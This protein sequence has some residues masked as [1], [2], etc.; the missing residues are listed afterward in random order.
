MNCPVCGFVMRKDDRNRDWCAHYI[1]SKY[2]A[3]Y[4]LNDDGSTT[5]RL[6]ELTSNK[7]HRRLLRLITIMNDLVF[8]DEERIEKLLLLI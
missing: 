7:K 1:G 6:Y 3:V 8:I 5:T 4:D 2:R